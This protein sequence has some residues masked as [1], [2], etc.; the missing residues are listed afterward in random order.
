MPHAELRIR[1][2]LELAGSD[3][4]SLSAG[5]IAVVQDPLEA[6]ITAAAA[7]GIT[8]STVLDKLMEGLLY[9]QQECQ[10]QS[11]EVERLRDRLE[12]YED[13]SVGSSD[14]E[15]QAIEDGATGEVWQLESEEQVTMGRV[16]LGQEERS[17]LSWRNQPE[18]V[19]LAVQYVATHPAQPGS[20][21]GFLL[22]GGRGLS[23]HRGTRAT[24]QNKGFRLQ[25]G[26]GV[27]TRV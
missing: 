3:G 10:Q 22:Y 9:L 23:A 6:V 21:S 20:Q 14:E 26:G 4:S 1:L 24:D 5:T 16:A 27:R 19:K 17:G 8:L 2:G 13:R 25:G 18:A 12:F 7:G 15:L 11:E